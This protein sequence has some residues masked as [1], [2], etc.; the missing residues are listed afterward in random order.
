MSV[1]RDFIKENDGRI[2]RVVES[3]RILFEK[4]D[5]R[6]KSRILLLDVVDGCKIQTKLEN[7]YIYFYKEQKFIF[8][9]F[10]VGNLYNLWFERRGDSSCVYDVLMEKFGKT[11]DELQ[12]SLKD[13]LDDYF[14]NI[15]SDI[16]CH[17][18]GALSYNI[19]GYIFDGVSGYCNI[20]E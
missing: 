5:E 15:G 11:N 14:K 2:L 12:K 17:S 19:G 20:Y 1:F 13:I 10:F 6:I 4:Y 9:I 16:R 3:R 18:I 8:K 7:D